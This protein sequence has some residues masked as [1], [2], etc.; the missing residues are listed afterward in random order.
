MINSPTRPTARETSS[1]PIPDPL[2]DRV[3]GMLFGFGVTVDRRLG[4][5]VTG[6]AGATDLTIGFEG[7]D[8]EDPV[9]TTNACWNGPSRLEVSTPG[10][11]RYEIRP[12]SIIC[13][14]EPSCPDQL[15]ELD[16]LGGILGTWMELNGLT[17]LHAAAISHGDRCVL[18]LAESGTG[19]SSLAASFVAAG[20]NLLADDLAA[21][22]WVHALP[23]V[24][25]A[26]PAMRLFTDHLERTVGRALVGLEPVVPGSPKRW[27]PVGGR[28]GFG[29]FAPGEL[30]VARIYV[31]HRDDAAARAR[32]ETMP[33]SRCVAELIR[34]SF[35]VRT[36]RDLGR[37]RARLAVIATLAE[38]VPVVRLR[39]PSG[40]DRLAE[41]RSAV[42]KDLA[43]GRQA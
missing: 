3:T 29:A 24:R 33:I 12:T 42:A 25:P 2:H 21:I 35:V 37:S 26:F 14:P 38:R 9:D 20:H 7:S 39:Y 10:I 28:H 23:C 36:M 6:S 22:A 17:V 40:F 16:V 13:R 31:C 43:V 41:V 34:H 8:S 30:P 4:R 19:K 27:V 18:F 11:A 1:A 15:L 32:V 5:A